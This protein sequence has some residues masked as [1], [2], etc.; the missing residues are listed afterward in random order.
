MLPITFLKNMR[1]FSAN[2]FHFV[3]LGAI[4]NCEVSCSSNP[5]AETPTDG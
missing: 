5:N 4:L 2:L 3:I 1:R